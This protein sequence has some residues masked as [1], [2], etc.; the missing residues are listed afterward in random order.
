MAYW[1]FDDAGEFDEAGRALPHLVARDSSGQ[2]NDLP[3]VVLP[4]P[5]DTSIQQASRPPSPVGR[6]HRAWRFRP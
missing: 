3:L 1:K 6:N 4:Q 2:G 5:R